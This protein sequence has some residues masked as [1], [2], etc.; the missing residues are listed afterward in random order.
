[1]TQVHQLNTAELLMT[2]VHQLTLLWH[3]SIKSHCWWHMYIKSDCF[4]TGSSTHTADDTCPLN[5]SADNTCPWIHTANKTSIKSYC[6]ELP[7]TCLFSLFIFGSLC[8][9]H[10]INHKNI[11]FLYLCYE[12]NSLKINMHLRYTHTKNMHTNTHLHKYT[13]THTYR[14]TCAQTHTHAHTVTLLTLSVIP[15]QTHS[16]FLKPGE[17]LLGPGCSW[18]Q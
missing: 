11:Y 7:Q 6:S 3:M 18:T 5:H 13:Y 16:P 12:P 2:R 9:N 8:T 1:M 10:F 14:Y 17:D 15:I 4:D